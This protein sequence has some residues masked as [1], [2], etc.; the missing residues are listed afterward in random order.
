MQNSHFYA[1]F[2]CV[3]GEQIFVKYLPCMVGRG[4]VI[5]DVPVFRVNQSQQNSTDYDTLVNLRLSGQESV[6]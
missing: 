5:R 1:K 4:R 6:N 2:Q 3:T